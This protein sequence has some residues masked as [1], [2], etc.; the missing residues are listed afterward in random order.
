MAA[1]DT[2]IPGA[3]TYATA[4]LNATTAYKNTL[5]RINAKRN[6]TLQQFGYQ[7]DVDPTSGV[8]GNVRVDPNSRYGGLQ[9]MLRNQALEDRNAEYGAEERGLHGG[10]ANQA[11]TDLKYSHGQQSADFG[12]GLTGV[13]GDLQDQQDTAGYAKNSALYQA[14]LDAAQQAILQQAFSPADYSGLD[15]PDYGEDPFDAPAGTTTSGGVSST[16]AK[17][18]KKLTPS[19]KAPSGYQVAK[20][21]SAYKE[22]VVQKA[23]PKT[24]AVK[25]SSAAVKKQTKK[26][27]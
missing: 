2:P 18:I 8:V 14:E 3:D 23:A 11:V 5:S 6:Q 16:K 27:G 15:Y 12:Q 20:N 25:L 24:A 26:G 22:P 13:L 9:Q 1:Y 4:N 21:T 17:L 19:S 10:L 7:G